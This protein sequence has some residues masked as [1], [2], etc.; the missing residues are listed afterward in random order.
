MGV[1]MGVLYTVF[2]STV[3]NGRLIP[4]TLITSKTDSFYWATFYVD[5][6]YSKAWHC[7]LIQFYIFCQFLNP[8]QSLYTLLHRLTLQSNEF[9]CSKTMSWFVQI[10]ARKTWGFY[11]FHSLHW[12]RLRKYVPHQRNKLFLQHYVLFCPFCPMITE[13]KTF[14]IT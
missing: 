12:T 3:R 14:Q 9:Q 5:I 7:G 6:I 8:G 1:L 11:I 10:Q 4:C 13:I 2:N